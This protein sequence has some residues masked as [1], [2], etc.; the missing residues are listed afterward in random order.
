MNDSSKEK[1]SFKKYLSFDFIKNFVLI[2]LGLILIPF[3]I[4][5]FANQEQFVND[6]T[7]QNNNIKASLIAIKQEIR[8]NHYSQ[9]VWLKDTLNAPVLNPKKDFYYFKGVYSQDYFVV[10][11]SNSIYL[12][13]LDDKYLAKYVIST[14]TWSKFIIDLL[15]SNSKLLDEYEYLISEQ[16]S[17]NNTYS[18]KM[19][20]N[21]LE[22]QLAENKRSL[23]NIY[24][25]LNS[26]EGQAIVAI[27]RA[28]LI[29][30]QKEGKNTSTVRN[31]IKHF[32]QQLEESKH[33]L[34]DQYKHMEADEQDQILDFGRTMKK[35]VK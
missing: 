6:R 13:Q 16:E 24:R 11:Q 18:L 30:D 7:V 8:S 15:N 3:L 28:I 27:D 1:F 4:M 2:I 22:L 26:D 19:R 17:G 32:T 5:H 9:N 31:R 23:K 35:N 14:Y 25:L 10:Y 29:I 33:F 20:I 21:V 34:K 12:G